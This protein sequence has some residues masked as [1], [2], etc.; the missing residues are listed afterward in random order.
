MRD[1]VSEHFFSGHA[2]C[3]AVCEAE[4]D[5]FF[6]LLGGDRGAV[7]LVPSVRLGSD[8]MQF[9]QSGRGIGVGGGVAVAFP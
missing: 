6:Q 5:V 4:G 3:V 8:E 9:A 7:L 1:D 2:A